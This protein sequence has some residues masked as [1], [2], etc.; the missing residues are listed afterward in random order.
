ML[1]SR[2][3]VTYENECNLVVNCLSPELINLTFNF[4]LQSVTIIYRSGFYRVLLVILTPYLEL[5]H[6]LKHLFFSMGCS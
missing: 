2:H 4:G 6:S 1:E 3:D 5:T